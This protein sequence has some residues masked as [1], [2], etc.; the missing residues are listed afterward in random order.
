MAL[1]SAD[2]HYPGDHHKCRD[3]EGVASPGSQKREC[4][5]V[6]GQYVGQEAQGGG[7]WN[8]THPP[9]WPSLALWPCFYIRQQPLWCPALLVTWLCQ[10]RTHQMWQNLLELAE[11]PDHTFIRRATPGLVCW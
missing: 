6:F 11:G 3:S 2:L 10:P 1:F 5:M 7:P 8:L 4:W 9:A